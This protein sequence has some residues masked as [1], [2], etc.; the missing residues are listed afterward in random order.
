MPDQN[1][2]SLMQYIPFIGLIA[3]NPNVKTPF[4]TKMAETAIMS[5]VAGGFA[6]YV[7]VEVIKSELTAIKVSM[8]KRFDNIEIK[9]EQVDSKVERVR[10]DLYIPRGKKE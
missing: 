4:G 8:E 7:S 5:V 1:C 6:L 3:N 2:H 10:G 9:V